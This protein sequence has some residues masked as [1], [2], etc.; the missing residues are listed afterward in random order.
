MRI[1]VVGHPGYERLPDVLATLAR[2]APSLDV[3]LLVEPEVATKS[4]SRSPLSENDEIDA[5]ITLGGDGTLLRGAKFLRGRPVPILGVNL[6]RLGFLTTCS[7][8]EAESALQ[9]LAS[10]DFQAEQRMALS[11]TVVG[12]SAPNGEWLALNDTVLHKGGFARVVALTVAVNGEPLGSYAAD[13]IVVATPTGSTGYSLSAGGPIVHPSVESIIITPISAHALAIRP[14]VI[15]PDAEVSVR[16]NDGPEELLLTVD[17]QGGTELKRGQ[18]L[19]VRRAPG[20]V[21]IVRF[22]GD[23]FFERIR[24][25]LGWGGIKERDEPQ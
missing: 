20:S 9:R 8:D 7:G 11:A 10:G 14:L 21:M 16:V 17:G 15:S 19:I 3:T 1:G 24:V 13:G 2:L 4:L 5:L 22:P 18:H 12:G 23:S 25:K 6:G